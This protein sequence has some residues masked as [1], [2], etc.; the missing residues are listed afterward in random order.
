MKT[1]FKTTAAV[2]LAISAFAC[3]PGP[4]A[5]QTYLHGN[6]TISTPNA[7]VEIHSHDRYRP[8][9]YLGNRHYVEEYR[10][11]RETWIPYYPAPGAVMPSQSRYY[12]PHY[13]NPE[14]VY[15]SPPGYGLVPLY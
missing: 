5:A 4:V 3:A 1:L 7:R 6:V 11:R 8:R 15:T 9:P 14:L 12:N 10:V 13:H 2:I